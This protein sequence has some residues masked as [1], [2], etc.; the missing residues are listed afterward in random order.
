MEKHT[1]PNKGLHIVFL[2]LLRI[3]RW[4]YSILFWIALTGH[5]WSS[6]LT[7]KNTVTY[8]YFCGNP[9]MGYWAQWFVGSLFAGILML[10][11]GIWSARH[12]NKRTGSVF[13]IGFLL[14]IFGLTLTLV[15]GVFLGTVPDFINFLGYAFG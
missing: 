1:S 4:L 9:L 12:K 13:L 8:D 6:V 2:T 10:P 11:G 15:A 7:L 3:A 14:Y 5:I